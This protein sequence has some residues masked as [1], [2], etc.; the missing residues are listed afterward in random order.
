MV[1]FSVPEQGSQELG[2]GGTSWG[3]QGSSK[4]SACSV[5]ASAGLERSQ[6]S[7][8]MHQGANRDHGDPTLGEG[9]RACPLSPLPRLGQSSPRW[10][11]CWGCICRTSELRCRVLTQSHLCSPQTAPS[12]VT[13]HEAAQPGLGGPPA[14][15]SRSAGH[16]EG[17][18]NPPPGP[19]SGMV[20]PGQRSPLWL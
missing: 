5:P 19:V 6:Y 13:R 20:F 8:A 17:S 4:G 2:G 14:A 12:G 7:P 16:A 9:N 10:R 11:C 3:R 15:I 18:R 1:I